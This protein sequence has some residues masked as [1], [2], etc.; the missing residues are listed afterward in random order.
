LSKLEDDVKAIVETWNVQ[1][2]AGRE[3]SRNDMYRFVAL[4]NDRT[5]HLIKTFRQYNPEYYM[6]LADISKLAADLTSD[7]PTPDEDPLVVAHAR[8]MISLYGV[9]ETDFYTGLQELCMNACTLTTP[10]AKLIA[11]GVDRTQL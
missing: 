1:K 10:G 8:N 9:N 5:R 7:T 6:I 2:W 4:M 3:F 11:D